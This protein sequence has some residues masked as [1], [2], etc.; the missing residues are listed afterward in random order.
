M[1]G[2]DITLSLWSVIQQGDANT[3]FIDLT[4]TK[5]KK[6]YIFQLNVVKN[7]L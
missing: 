6:D 3:M 4:I 7:I 5:L 1:K 2:G